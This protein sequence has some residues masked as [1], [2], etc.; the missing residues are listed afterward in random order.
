VGVSLKGEKAWSVDE[1]IPPGTYLFRPA[2]NGLEKDESGNKAPQ[3]K[4]NWR[5]AA[6]EYTGA[7]RLDW[8]TFTENAMGRVVQLL[9]A[10]GLEVPQEDFASYE[11]LRDWVLEQL[12]K[13]GIQTMGVVR[14]KESRKDPSKSF[15]EI[16]GYKAPSES[17]IPNDTSGFAKGP[18]VGGQARDNDKVPF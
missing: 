13:D 12:S 1:Q 6:G 17:D 4:V 8:V 14:L 7:E 11:A 15:P 9:E 3:I 2:P 5:V 16:V 10:C 18:N